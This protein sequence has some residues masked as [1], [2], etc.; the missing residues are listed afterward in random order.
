MNKKKEKGWIPFSFFLA[1]DK[2]ICIIVLYS[3]VS[4][5]DRTAAGGN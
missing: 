2:K 5:K 3:A 4:A 1:I